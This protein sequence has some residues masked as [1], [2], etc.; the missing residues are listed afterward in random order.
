MRLI[1]KGTGKTTIARLY[2]SFLNELGVIS[3]SNFAETTGATLVH[4][5]VGCLQKLISNVGNG[6]VLFI[7]EA[8]QLNPDTE[9]A[10]RRVLDIL[11]TEM[12]NKIGK[13]VVALAGYQVNYSSQLSEF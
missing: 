11:L 13:L 8:Y 4:E 7:D 3:G 2:S 10:G 6:G 5:G 1:F 12:E 9:S